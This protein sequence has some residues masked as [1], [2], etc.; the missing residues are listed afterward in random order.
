MAAN[1]KK[2]MAVALELARE[3]EGLTR[4]NPPVGCVLVKNN[5]IVGRGFH[6]R[7]G[8]LHAERLALAAAGN[9]A[10]N[11]T[12][13]VTLEPC[14]THGR[15]PPCTEA[16]ITAGIKRVV[17]SVNDPNPRH[18]GRGLRILRRAG[19]GVSTGVL[20]E[21][22]ARLLAPFAK[23]IT[24]G[25][26]YV[27]LKLAMSVDGRIADRSDNARWISGKAS[28]IYVQAVRRTVD[29]V[30]VGAGTA[31]SDNPSL[32]PRPAYG[33]KPFR[34]II[35]GRKPLPA[36]LGVFTDRYAARTILALGRHPS[37]A[38]KNLYEKHGARVWTMPGQ[39]GR[40]NMRT[41]LD[42]LGRE[43][44]L[45]VLCE[46]GGELAAALIEADRV[47]RYL[48]FYAPKILG[49]RDATPSVGGKGWEQPDWRELDFQDVRRV[50]TDICVTAVP[51]NK[52]RLP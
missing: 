11:A 7:A 42:H 28:R 27:T 12:A 30:M 25:R 44:I 21:E 48:L 31:R 14:S 5:R 17:V 29:A 22:G 3:G 8:G 20:A 24:T 19:M 15:T 47:D 33:R 32:C 10:R 49:G 13:Y 36:T 40:V 51:L 4:P 43:G 38:Q 50:G 39:S 1:D 16:L 2:W 34:I 23:W 18:A 6:H 45:H 52:Q 9:T 35:G 37:S 41:L 46:G 26:P